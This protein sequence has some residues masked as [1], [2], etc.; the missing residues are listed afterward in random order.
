MKNTRKLLVAVFAIVLIFTSVGIPVGA[1]VGI[2]NGTTSPGEGNTLENAGT[3]AAVPGGPGFVMI[4]PTAFVPMFSEW[5]YSFGI[6]GG[7]LYNPGTAEYYYEAAVNL[8]HG[9][10]IT[11]VVVYYFD[12]S[13]T[14][15]IWVILAGISMDDY[16]LPNLA[17]LVTSGAE[18]NN[19][20]M[21]DTTISP[22]VIDNQSF[23]YWVE[24]G[25]P[26]NESSNLNL[27][28]IRI[29]YEYPVSLP[30]INK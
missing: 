26:G 23:A 21:E 9:A 3:N 14:S 7:A 22:D 4:H 27:R 10:K 1:Q 6:G 17:Y 24:V 13:A 11:K 30:L 18:A 28:G 12:N 29:D 20:V 8:P 5:P 19:R 16:L 2:D 15:N 25:I